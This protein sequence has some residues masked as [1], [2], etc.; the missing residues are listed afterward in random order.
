MKI[1]FINFKK[2]F[3]FDQFRLMS[4]NMVNCK[5]LSVQKYV[6][7]ILDIRFKFLTKSYGYN[8]PILSK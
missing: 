4:K 7:F 5:G 1:I 6:S 2:K 3:G 8:F